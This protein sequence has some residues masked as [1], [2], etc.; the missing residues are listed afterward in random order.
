MNS[1]IKS[2]KKQKVIVAYVLYP[3]S[4]YQICQVKNNLTKDNPTKIKNKMMKQMNNR[5]P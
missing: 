5:P 1:K 2:I 4:L 3:C